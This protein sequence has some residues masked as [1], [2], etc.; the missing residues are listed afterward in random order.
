[1]ETSESKMGLK[2]SD[3]YDD[4]RFNKDKAKARYWFKRAADLG[5]ATGKEGLER[6]K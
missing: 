4:G 2:K 5:N 1:M 3:F 6:L